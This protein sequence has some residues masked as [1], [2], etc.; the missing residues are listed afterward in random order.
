MIFIF[1]KLRSF[2]LY[3]LLVLIFCL[4]W[5]LRVFPFFKRLISNAMDS[6][7][8]LKMPQDD[9]WDS[10]FTRQMLKGLWRF[11]FLDLNKKTKLGA[12]AYNSPLFSM[13]GKKCFRLLEM[14]QCGRPLVVNFGSS[15]WRPF[16]TKLREFG[17]IVRDFAD[18]ADFVIVYIEEAHPSDGWAFKVGLSRLVVN[19]FPHNQVRKAIAYIM[20]HLPYGTHFWHQQLKKADVIICDFL[21][22][23]ICR[24][25]HPYRTSLLTCCSCFCLRSLKRN[26]KVPF[27]TGIAK[28]LPVHTGQLKLIRL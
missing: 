3:S 8:G 26:V 15:S 23:E 16:L 10:M 7:S 4:G 17:E 11:I 9:Y 18:I 27:T 2:A 1:Q 14:S 19:N 22:F 24:E 21:N 6:V 28:V 12:K 20:I 13:D 5:T 25:R